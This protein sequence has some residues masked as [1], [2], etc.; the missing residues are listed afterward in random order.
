MK[1]IKIH[2]NYGNSL[3]LWKFMGINGNSW[4]LMEINGN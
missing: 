3:K 2:E 1:F 4:E